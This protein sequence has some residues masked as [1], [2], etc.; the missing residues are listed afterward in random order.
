MVPAYIASDERMVSIHASVA[1]ISANK[2]QPSTRKENAQIPLVACL[3][4]CAPSHFL[5]TLE[6]YVYYGS[7]KA[8]ACTAQS[9]INS[10]RLR[11]PSDEYSIEISINDG[12]RLD[13]ARR[14]HQHDAGQVARIGRGL[15]STQCE[16]MCTYL[17]NVTAF[18]VLFFS[19]LEPTNDAEWYPRWN[20]IHP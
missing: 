14:C 18:C 20:S 9:Y 1:T 16:D 13:G 10:N 8:M 3:P 7:E 4:R 15:D 5:N 19:Y 17:H 6:A 11:R 12:Q 2:Q